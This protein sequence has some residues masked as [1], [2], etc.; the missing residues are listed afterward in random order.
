MYS[1]RQNVAFCRVLGILELGFH[2]STEHAFGFDGDPPGPPHLKV[3]LATR[4]QSNISNRLCPAYPN[5]EMGV[6]GC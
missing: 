2:I 6:Q 3:E 4:N 1:S 5:T